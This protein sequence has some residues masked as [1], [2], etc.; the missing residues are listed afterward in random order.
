MKPEEPGEAVAVGTG[1]GD[2]VALAEVVPGEAAP[3]A[4]LILNVH[5]SK[6]KVLRLIK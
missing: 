4:A 6:G 3:L 2:A 5:P 1:V